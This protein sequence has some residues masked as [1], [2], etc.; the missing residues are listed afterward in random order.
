MIAHDRHELTLMNF[1]EY[2][3][4]QALVNLIKV[5]SKERFLAYS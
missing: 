2:G 1:G 5:L 3:P 4:H